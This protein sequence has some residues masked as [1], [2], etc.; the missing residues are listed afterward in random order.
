MDDKKYIGFFYGNKE[1][2]IIQLEKSI[3]LYNN[4]RNKTPKV[5]KRIQDYKNLLSEIKHM[6][7]GP[8]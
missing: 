5:L 6:T 3:N 7:N 4:S 1:E 2:A 8:T